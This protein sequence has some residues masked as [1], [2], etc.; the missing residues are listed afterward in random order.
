[1]FSFSTSNTESCEDQRKQKIKDFDVIFFEDGMTYQ[2]SVQVMLMSA[3]Q[4]YIP[5]KKLQGSTLIILPAPSNTDE[6][7]QIDNFIKHFLK[8]KE[9]PK[10]TD[11]GGSP[12]K[13]SKEN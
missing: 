2:K 10:K 5:E 1:M 13:T 12:C 4:I 3:F 8:E 9:K 7:H 11:F 6:I